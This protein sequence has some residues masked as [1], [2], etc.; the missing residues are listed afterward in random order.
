M[1]YVAI[2]L[3]KPQSNRAPDF[4]I[5]VLLKQDISISLKKKA[6]KKIW[7]QLLF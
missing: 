3:K 2:Y 4:G 1:K 5:L 7:D 6:Q